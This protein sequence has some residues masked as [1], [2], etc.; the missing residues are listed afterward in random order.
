M[1][2][3]PRRLDAKAR[4]LTPVYSCSVMSPVAHVGD[5]SLGASQPHVSTMSA[6]SGRGDTNPVHACRLG[7]WRQLILVKGI[8][9]WRKRRGNAGGSLLSQAIRMGATEDMA[10]LGVLR[11]LVPGVH[12]GREPATVD[13]GRSTI[14]RAP[15]VPPLR[16]GAR[17]RLRVFLVAQDSL[18]CSTVSGSTAHFTEPARTPATYALTR[19]SA[20]VIPHGAHPTDPL[21]SRG[22]RAARLPRVRLPSTA[23]SRS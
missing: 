20:R 17:Q 5:T 16:S 8:V 7:S 19:S 1:R 21:V 6:Q 10:G 12:D 4:P 11:T 2:A 22:A 3:G 23:A 18:P 14:A 15:G 9:W 13:A